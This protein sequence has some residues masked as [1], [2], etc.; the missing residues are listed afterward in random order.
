MIVLRV[1]GYIVLVALI[2]AIGATIGAYMVNWAMRAS[3][4]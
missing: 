3:G 4:Y 1:F 2:F